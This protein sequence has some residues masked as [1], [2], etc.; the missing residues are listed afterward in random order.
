MTS[1]S[2]ERSTL[3]NLMLD[4]VRNSRIELMEGFKVVDLL[5]EDDRV[6]G[7]KGHDETKTKFNINAKMV[8][9]A[10]GRNSVSLPRLN[11]RKNSPGK[12][13]IALAAHWEN[14][15][16]FWCKEFVRSI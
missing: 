5:F 7:V 2:V 14:V 11:L 9:D 6:C 8:I 13:K 1:L 10:G 12:G 16:F 15:E 3:D 4:K